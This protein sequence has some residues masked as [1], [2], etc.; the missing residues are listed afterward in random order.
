MR[1]SIIV[2]AAAAAILSGC[3]KREYVEDGQ[4]SME[5]IEQTTRY[6]I[7][8]H[9]TTGICYLVGINCICPLYEADGTFYMI[10]D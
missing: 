7:Y 10:G 3:G 1:K 2:L 8:R 9:R 6:A 4:I 5:T